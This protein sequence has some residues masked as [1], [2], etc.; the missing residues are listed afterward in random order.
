M[1]KVGFQNTTFLAAVDRSTKAPEVRIPGVPGLRGALSYAVAR[2]FEGQADLN[3]DGKVTVEELFNQVRAVVYQL[4]D[5]RQT[6]V[7]FAPPERDIQRDVAFALTEQ[8]RQPAVAAGGGPS[9]RAKITITSVDMEPPQPAASAIRISS[10]DPKVDL[11]G[12]QQRDSAF[13]VGRSSGEADL[14]WD[15][16]SGDVLSGG[17]V[18]AYHVDKQELPSV[19]DR[20]AAVQS[21]KKLLSRSPQSM[22]VQPDDALHHEHSKVVVDVANVEG[23][24]LILFNIASDGTVQALYPRGGDSPFLSDSKYR[25]PLLVRSPFGADQMVAITSAQRL[26]A[27]EQVVREYDGRRGAAGLIKLIQRYAPKDARFGSVGIFTAR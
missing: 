10:L 5:Q 12:L 16:R 15:P 3:G 13:T 22:N 7:T 14:V 19:I 26:L 18:V 27:L 20:T 25:L 6:P 17:D 11:S 24:A 8:A 21:L 23:R 2:A 1:T 9:P 4:S